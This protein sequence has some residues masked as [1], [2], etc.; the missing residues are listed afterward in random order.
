MKKKIFVTVDLEDNRNKKN[1][2]DKPYEKQTE[3]ITNWLC[4][5]KIKATFFDV[6]TFAK[7]NPKMIKQISYDHVI[8]F[9][10]F[11]HLAF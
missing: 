6:G 9:H 10:S 5:N 3:I 4:K 2:A 8:A 7:N 1:A 11:D